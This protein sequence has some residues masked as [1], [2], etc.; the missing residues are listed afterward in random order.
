MGSSYVKRAWQFGIDDYLPLI[1]EEAVERIV[2]KANR[3]RGMRVVHISSTFYGGGVAEMLSSLT[4]L[5]RHLGI[6][7]DWRLIQGSPDFFRV[8]KKLHNALQGAELEI[9]DEAKRVYEEVNLQNSMRMDLD[10]DVVIV[11]DPQPLPLIRHERRRCPWVWR[12]HVDL[13]RPDPHVWAY[14]R[15]MVEEYD[16]VVLSLPEYAQDL[17]IPQ[18]FIAPGID[19]FALKNRTMSATEIEERLRHYDIPMDLPIVAQ[20][21]RF[22]R[23]KDPEGAIAAFSK[24]AAEVPATLVLLGN[25]ATDDPEGQEVFEAMIRKKTDRIRIMTAEDSAFVNALQSRAAVVLQ[26]SIREGFGLT[27]TEALWKGAA[28]LARPVGG[29][30][31]QIEDGWNGMLANSPDEAAARIVQALR[32]PEYRATLGS[33]ARATVRERFLH[34]RV[35]EDQFDLLAAFEPRFRLDAGRL[36][37]LTQHAATRWHD[38]PTTKGRAREPA[39]QQEPR[40]K[41]D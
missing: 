15:S 3:L 36:P 16:A 18:V 40:G 41:A 33:R 5:E 14:L 11:H 7:S 4:L 32:D 38:A 10:A 22:D 35:V 27:V 29:I 31:H 12:G 13:T 9:S 20:I 39:A 21:S 34:S 23:W 8:T 24:A 25:I 2:R 28:V 19:P 26:M 1:G 17:S 6:E 37:A 30:R